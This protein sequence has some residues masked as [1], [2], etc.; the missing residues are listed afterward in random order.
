MDDETDP[1]EDSEIVFRR[2]PASMKEWYDS[3][4]GEVSPEAFGPRKDEATGISFA[5][6]KYKSASE[7]GRGRLGKSFYVAFLKVSDMRKAGIRVDSRPLPGDPGHSEL[8]DLNCNNRKENETIEKQRILAS[9][10]V[11]VDGPFTSPAE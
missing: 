2:I 5:R 1:I 3:D 4:T 9:L 6:Q 8:P 10:V 7:A 11:S